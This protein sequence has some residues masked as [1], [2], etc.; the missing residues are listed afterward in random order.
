MHYIAQYI[1]LKIL[2]PRSKVI[3]KK[4]GVFYKEPYYHNCYTVYYGNNG[5]VYKV[6]K[7]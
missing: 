3:C 7:T 4:D 5:T 2:H 6:K 1:L